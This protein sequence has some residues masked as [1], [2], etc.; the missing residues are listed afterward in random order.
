MKTT[1][2]TTRIPSPRTGEG[3]TGDFADLMTVTDAPK[4]ALLVR[5]LVITLGGI[6]PWSVILYFLATAWRVAP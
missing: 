2:I 5:V 1:A 3:R 4:F 6:L